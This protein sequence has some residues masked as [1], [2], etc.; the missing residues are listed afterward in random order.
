MPKV[1][2]F[3]FAE[4]SLWRFALRPVTL[5]V[6]DDEALQLNLA[7]ITCGSFFGDQQ[8]PPGFRVVSPSFGLASKILVG[9]EP[10]MVEGRTNSKTFRLTL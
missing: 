7:V 9:S 3:V 1:G 5:G 8:K 2:A 10:W 6:V 4:N